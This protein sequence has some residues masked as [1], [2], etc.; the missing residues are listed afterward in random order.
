SAQRPDIVSSNIRTGVSLDDFDPATDFYLNRDAFTP[1]AAGQFGNAPPRLA[2][3]GPHSLQESFAILKNTKITERVTHQF[4]FEV[5]NPM[6]RVVFGN[7]NT[8]ITSANFGRISS[9]GAPRNIQF[10]MKMMF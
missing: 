1:A 6:N 3:Q 9:V 8:N 2:V 10:G 5:N 7:P 4:R